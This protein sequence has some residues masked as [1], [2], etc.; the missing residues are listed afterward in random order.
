MY[1]IGLFLLTNLAIIIVASISLRLLG[2]ESILA[3]NGV[4]LNLSALLIFC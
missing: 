4:D 3:N 1:R 2:V